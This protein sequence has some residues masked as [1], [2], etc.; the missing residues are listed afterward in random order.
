MESHRTTGMSE[1]SV[2]QQACVNSVD[3]LPIAAEE[4]RSL[5]SRTDNRAGTDPRDAV[6]VLHR[7]LGTPDRRPANPAYASVQQRLE[8]AYGIP[9]AEAVPVIVQDAHGRACLST[10]PPIHRTSMAPYSVQ[11]LVSTEHDSRPAHQE[12]Q[13]TELRFRE[14]RSSVKP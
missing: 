5:L 12:L 13:Q 10:C 8:R 3:R 2:S 14:Y 1:E 9:R 4:C 11:D 7:A 6:G